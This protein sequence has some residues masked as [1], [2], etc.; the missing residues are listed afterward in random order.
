MSMMSRLRL[1]W[2]ALRH[3]YVM[4]DVV[5]VEPGP[6]KR[7]VHQWIGMLVHHPHGCVTI[8][9]P[10]DQ[11]VEDAKGKGPQGM[12]P[13][14]PRRVVGPFM[15]DARQALRN[16]PVQPLSNSSGPTPMLSEVTDVESPMR[17]MSED[18]TDEER[19]AA[20]LKDWDDRQ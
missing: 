16:S 9:D 3:G 2:F 8:V 18:A 6:R 7:T 13:M 11:V 17:Y 10:H 12:H 19:E 4:V 5:R 20:V 14:D 15:T 1:A